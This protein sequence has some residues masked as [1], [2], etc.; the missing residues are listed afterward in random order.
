[1]TTEAGRAQIC[2]QAVC[3]SKGGELSLT[4]AV[5]KQKEC[6]VKEKRQGG[7]Q[8]SDCNNWPSYRVRKDDERGSKS[9]KV[10]K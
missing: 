3:E 6:N 5:V 1:M 7:T 10:A 9:E 8:G 2:Q 4:R